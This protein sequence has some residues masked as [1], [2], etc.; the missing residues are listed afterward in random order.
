MS[1]EYRFA[2]IDDDRLAA[3]APR[4]WREKSVKMR[5]ERERR[6]ELVAGGLL[7]DMLPEL[8]SYDIALT[9][10]GK[11]Y[12][13][14]YPQ[15]HFS[16]SHSDEVVM[17]AISDG[18]VGCDVERVVELSAE[19]RQKIGSIE[20]WTLKEAEFK[21]GKSAAAAYSVPAP[22]GYSAAIAG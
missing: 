10:S 7:A 3:K 20:L 22:E 12:L 15:L 14:N 21:R 2:R 5:F 18:P 16:L 19:M 8:K 4:H 6:Q 11:P 1:V 17:C 9:P 13:V